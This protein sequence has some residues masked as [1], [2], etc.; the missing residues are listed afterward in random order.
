[1]V[2]PVSNSLVQQQIPVNNAVQPGVSDSTRRPEE[3]RQP[4][5]T[6]VQGNESARTE[7][8]DN[9]DKRNLQAA[10]ADRARDTGGVSSSTSR[11]T[12]L[13]ITA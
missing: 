11:G 3:Q 10:S 4:D 12:Q 13:N 2:L 8:S 9:R 6:R 7:R 5:A 1:M